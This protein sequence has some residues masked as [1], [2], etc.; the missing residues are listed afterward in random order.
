MLKIK[1]DL[2]QYVFFPHNWSLQ[3]KEDWMNARG[4]KIDWQSL[5]WGRDDQ[6]TMRR[7]FDYHYY[8][9]RMV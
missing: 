2:Y 7:G 1:E 9:F 4:H 3:D 8:A 5:I 6:W